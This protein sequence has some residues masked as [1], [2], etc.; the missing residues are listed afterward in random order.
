MSTRN[1]SFFTNPLVVVA[2]GAAMA[3]AVACGD[4]DDSANPAPGGGTK[5]T[6]GTNGTA[7]K[8]TGGNSTAGKTNNMAGTPTEVAG[9]GGAGPVPETGG[10]GAGGAPD[11]TDDADLGCYSCKPSTTDQYLNQ[12]PTT[13]CK[14]FDNATLT[15]VV[16]GKLPKLP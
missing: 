8:N 2:L 4:D 12:C 5:A 3:F 13:G 6:G 14:G 1:K 9:G 7:G 10:A 16:N 15:S 11:C